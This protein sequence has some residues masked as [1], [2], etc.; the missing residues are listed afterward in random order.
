MDFSY[1]PEQQ[2][3]RKEIIAFSRATLNAGVV[4]RDR[5][6]TFSREL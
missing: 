3:L 4:E 5:Q 6:Q 2:Q 1:T